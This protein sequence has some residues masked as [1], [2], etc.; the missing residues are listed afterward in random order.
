[1]ALIVAIIAIL[2]IW[3]IYNVLKVG[4][5]DGESGKFTFGNYALIFTHKYYVGAIINTL[6]VGTLGMLGACILGIPFAYILARYKIKARSFVS[7]LAVLALVSPPFIGAYAWI[8][9]LG[10]NGMITRALN[11]FGIQIPSIYG[12]SGIVLVFSFKFYPFVYL[13]TEAALKSI[14]RSFEEAAENLGCSPFERFTKVTPPLVF[15]AVSWSHPLLYSLN[16][17]F[18]HTF[19][20][21]ARLSHLGDHCL[22]SVHFRAWRPA[23]T[24]SDYFNNNDRDFDGLGLAA[25]TN[26]WQKTLQQFAN[27]QA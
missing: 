6:V 16:C 4:L 26:N 23:D 10:S 21:W 17:R 22:Q 20:N 24:C 5:I 8:M 3:P 14:N 11:N 2:L 13:M 15:P 18:R 1:M 12:M 27:Q 19:N 7:T 9:M 25:E